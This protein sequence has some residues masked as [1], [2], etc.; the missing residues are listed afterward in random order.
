MKTLSKMTKIELLQ[1]IA[2]QDAQIKDLA[3]KA[4]QLLGDKARLRADV[5]ELEAQKQD[6]EV[7][8]YRARLRVWGVAHPGVLVRSTDTGAYA[9]G[10]LVVPR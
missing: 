7:I 9:H 1:H 5:E 10:V 2:K 8:P 6:G 4:T 3:A